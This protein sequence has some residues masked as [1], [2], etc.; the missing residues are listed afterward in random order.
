MWTLSVSCWSQT[1]SILIS[2]NTVVCSIISRGIV[3]QLT[4]LLS[5]GFSGINNSTSLKHRSVETVTFFKKAKALFRIRQRT[6]ICLED[7]L[8]VK[9]ATCILTTNM[10]QKKCLMILKN[11]KNSSSV[12][13]QSKLSPNLVGPHAVWFG[14]MNSSRSWL[15][16]FPGLADMEAAAR[17]F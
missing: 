12:F 17:I 4:Q 1:S 3:F 16:E 14:S 2:C 9:G 7:P 15:W 5:C 13:R 10:E 8:W 6:L 11:L